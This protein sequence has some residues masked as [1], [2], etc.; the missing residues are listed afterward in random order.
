MPTIRTIVVLNGVAVDLVVDEEIIKRLKAGEKVEDGI[1]LEIP[2]FNPS[3]KSNI[4][5]AIDINTRRNIVRASVDERLIIRAWNQNEYMIARQSDKFETKN[6]R[7]PFRSIKDA[8]PRIRE[9][10]RIH[11]REWVINKINSYFKY[12]SKGHHIVKSNNYGYGTLF[13]FLAALKLIPSGGN[14]WWEKETSVP[15]DVVKLLKHPLIKSVAETYARMVLGMDKYALDN[16]DVSS[17]IHFSKAAKMITDF[18]RDRK[19]SGESIRRKDLIK[20]LIESLKDYWKD[21]AIAPGNLDSPITWNQILP[22]Y[23]RRT[24]GVF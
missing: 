15:A 20:Y 11:N 7:L 17:V 3:S 13:G 19:K 8:I 12:C 1:Y 24:V 22:N 21:R 2:V 18:V 14:A 6:H 23:L 5:S 4:I 16:S 10:L 9:V